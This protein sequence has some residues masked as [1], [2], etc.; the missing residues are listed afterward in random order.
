MALL[1]HYPAINNI[2][3]LIM[4]QGRNIADQDIKY[5]NIETALLLA[6]SCY[7]CLIEVFYLSVCISYVHICIFQYA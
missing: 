6:S 1:Q 7:L 3:L 2:T 5:Q 4:S